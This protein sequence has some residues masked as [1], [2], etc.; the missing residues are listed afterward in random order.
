MAARMA[1]AVGKFHRVDAGAVQHQRQEVADAGFVV[2]DITKRRLGRR[3]R[4]RVGR[5]SLA[6]GLVHRCFGRLGH[7]IVK[8]ARVG[9]INRS[10]YGI[11]VPKFLKL[12]FFAAGRRA[13]KPAK[14]L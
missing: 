3:Q 4:R 9:D 8:R 10:G 6:V 1:V 5:R 11:C 12:G 2:D 13:K 14:S 7:A